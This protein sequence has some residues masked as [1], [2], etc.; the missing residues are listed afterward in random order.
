MVKTEL[1]DILDRLSEICEITRTANKDVSIF[2]AALLSGFITLLLNMFIAKDI[3]LAYVTYLGWFLVIVSAIF[4]FYFIIKMYSNNKKTRS[5]EQIY[6]ELIICNGD[7]DVESVKDMLK[8]VMMK[9]DIIDIE[10]YNKNRWV[11]QN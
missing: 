9:Q 2:I 6:N 1:K 8:A 5:F 4:S 3:N 7:I 11:K 10:K